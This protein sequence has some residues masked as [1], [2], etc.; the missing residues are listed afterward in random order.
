MVIFTNIIF[1]QS[2]NNIVC[3]IVFF[4]IRVFK[5]ITWKWGGLLNL[6]CSCLTGIKFEHF[7]SYCKI[8]RNYWLSLNHFSRVFEVTMAWPKLLSWPWLGLVLQF[9][10][11]FYG[12]LSL[13]SSLSSLLFILHRPTTA[14]VFFLLM[15]IIDIFC[16]YDIIITVCGLEIRRV[17]ICVRI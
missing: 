10:D 11:M 12:F 8:Q 16:Q 15:K 9:I 3:F 5:M 7:S 1:S 14:E 6:D 13:L 17:N 4:F 2:K